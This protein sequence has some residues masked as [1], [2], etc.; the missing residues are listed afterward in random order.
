MA[1]MWLT[2]LFLSLPPLPLLLLIIYL[3]RDAL[4]ALVGPE[5]GVFILI[6][7]VIG[8][9]RWMQVARLVRAQFLSLREKE[10]VEAA[11][12]LGA[13][14]LRLV[15]RHILPNSLGPVIVAGTIDVAVAII[16]E[17]TLSFL[18]L[19]FPPDIPTWGRI[20]FDAKDYLDIAPHW[21][22]FAGRR[23]SSSPCWRSTSSAT[24]CATRSIRAG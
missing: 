19:G 21:A 7:A 5:V 13:T 6:V 9:F 15:V 11:R 8:G 16:A 12:A 17:S 1:L 23:R 24:G 14:R 18:G 4:K 20:L 3:F 22:L 2:D 10:F